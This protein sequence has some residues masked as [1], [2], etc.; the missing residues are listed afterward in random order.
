M[1]V[2]H[3]S[4]LAGLTGQFLNGKHEFSELI[5]T[6]MVL[7]MDQSPSHLLFREFGELLLKKCTGLF[8]RPEQSIGKKLHNFMHKL[9]HFIS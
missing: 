5:L 8:G 1:V 3:L 7:L 4:G 9:I 2:F 6:R